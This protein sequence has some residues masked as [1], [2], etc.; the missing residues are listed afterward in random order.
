MHCWEVIWPFL[1]RGGGCQK[2]VTT[3]P[4]TPP[5]PPPRPYTPPTYHFVDKVSQNHAGSNQKLHS[6]LAPFFP[7]IWWNINMDAYHKF[8]KYSDTQNICCNHCNIWTMRLYHRV[9]SPKDA[10]GMANSVDP[11]LG[12]SDLGLHCLLRLSVRK[13]RVITVSPQSQHLKN[14]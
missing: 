9:M 6:K 3:P 1:S 14:I 12:E 7:N 13:L 10:D 5:P 11:A 4:S 2:D 8:P